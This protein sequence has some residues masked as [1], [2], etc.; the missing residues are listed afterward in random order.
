M[1]VIK[2]VN[3]AIRIDEIH[4]HGD[5]TSDSQFLFVFDLNEAGLITTSLVVDGTRY[6]PTRA[7]WRQISSA[8]RQMGN[9]LAGVEA[10]DAL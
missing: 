5:E 10:L 3:H 7:Q 4:H 8:A 9:K 2:M 1:A 6:H